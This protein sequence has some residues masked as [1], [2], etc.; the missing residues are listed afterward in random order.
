MMMHG[1]SAAAAFDSRTVQEKLTDLFGMLKI[2]GAEEEVVPASNSAPPI[3]GDLINRLS[4]EV[5]Q[6][7]EEGHMALGQPIQVD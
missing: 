1:T 4:T 7:A 6:V 2:E 3:T 5:N